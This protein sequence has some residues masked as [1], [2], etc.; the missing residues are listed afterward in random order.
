[1]PLATCPL[2]EAACGIVVDLDGDRIRSIR[3]DAD[4]PLSRGYVCPKASMLADLHH[5]PDRLRT[6][7]VREGTVWRE[8]SW[9]SALDRAADGLRAVRRRH[10][11]DAVAIYYGNPV[12]HNLG[13]MTHGLTFARAL[14]SRNVYSASSADQLP[15]M[16]VAL[17][18]FGHLA[19]I[20]VPDLDRTDFLFVVGANPVVSN[21]SLMTAPDMRRRLRAIRSRGGRVVV[22][23][24]RRTET[25]D[26]ADEH[27]FIRPGTDAWLLAGM[28]HVVF[29]EGLTRLAHLEDSARGLDRLAEVVRDLSPERAARVTGVDAATTRR[30]AR[31]LGRTERAAGYGRVGLCT[32]RYGTLAC[33]LLQALNTVTGHLD[34]VGGMMFTTPAVDVVG[35]LSRLGLRG[36]RDRWRSRVRELPEFGGDL[37]VAALA[38]EIQAEGDRAIRALVTI[39]G[40]PVLS[41]PNGRRLDRALATLDHVVSIDPYLNE[42]TRHAN[43]I[44]PP[45]PPLSRGHYAL[46]L[47]AFSVRNV[48]KYAEPAIAPRPSERH[49]WEILSE[50]GGR[51]FAPGPLRPL[52]ARALRALRPD[53]LVDAMLRVGPYRLSLEALRR[54]PHGLDLGPL[55]PGRLAARLATPDRRIDLAPD[56]FVRA[57]R[58]QLL[59]AD[60]PLSTDT[61]LLIGR[62]QT[63]GNNSWMHNSERTVAAAAARCTLLVHPCDAERRGLAT[64]GVARIES[65][66]GTIDTPVEVTDA[67]MPGVVSLP[68]GWGHD[69]DGSRL[70]VARRQPG[71]SINDVTSERHL[72]SLSGNAAFNGLPVRLTRTHPGPGGAEAPGAPRGV[73][74]AQAPSGSQP[75]S[76]PKPAGG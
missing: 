25:A 10:G 48:A 49:D 36:S 29:E 75:R 59:D 6:P 8:A 27:V 39:A 33:W 69:R 57:A 18:M 30:L 41:A 13:L 24:P 21:G 40:N 62:R 14:R 28:L 68:H 58:A 50:L 1:V 3:G 43:V 42:T 67:V 63:L 20:P 12:A 60:E 52:A 44:L 53:R 26:A 70:R 17:R 9:E 71:V 54:A 11:R 61:L 34:E 32:Q 72:D 38:D 76:G 23:D 37:P 2:C 56:E 55:Q 64:G 46:P 22:V 19:L 35:I 31:E 15:Q 16:L 7:L 65:G 74:P 4:D 47:Y 5:D 45:A 73:T 66:A 51:L